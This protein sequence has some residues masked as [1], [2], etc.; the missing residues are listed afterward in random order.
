MEY[1]QLATDINITFTELV[2]LIQKFDAANFNEQ[3]FEGS[4]TAG[5]LVSHVEMSGTGLSKALHD[6]A[7]D[8]ERAPDELVEKLKAIFLDF[9]TKMNSPSFIVPAEKNYE[10]EQL[11][12]SIENIQHLTIKGIETLD[13]TKT[14]TTFSLPMLGF[15]TRLEI[16]YFILYH[17][18]RHVHQLKNI[19]QALGKKSANLS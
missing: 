16:I 14:A 11:L 2:Q 8:T 3:P 7:K 9:S 6:A 4:W 15:I 17:T 12:N 5:Q 18:Q 19:H 10:I 1:N 13:L